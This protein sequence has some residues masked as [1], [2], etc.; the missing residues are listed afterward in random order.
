MTLVKYSLFL[1]A[2]LVNSCQVKD[3]PNESSNTVIENEF[4]TEKS[5][6]TTKK[7]YER[8]ISN[9]G[10]AILS[11]IKN[12]KRYVISVNISNGNINWEVPFPDGSFD[13]YIGDNNFGVFYMIGK[14]VVIN[15]KNGSKVLEYQ[16]NNTTN[17]LRPA[18]FDNNFYIVENNNTKLVAFNLNST[19]LWENEIKNIIDYTPAGAPYLIDGNFLL[20]KNLIYTKS[21]NNIKVFD[22]ETGKKISDF[23]FKSKINFLS[24]FG[25]S[26]LILHNGESIYKFE[27]TKSDTTKLFTFEKKFNGFKFFLAKKNDYIILYDYTNIYGIDLKTGK[28][29]WIYDQVLYQDPTF[30][31]NNIYH[32]LGG[33]R[34]GGSSDQNSTTIVNPENGNIINV[35]EKSNE[36]LPY[37]HFRGSLLNDKNYFIKVSN[38]K[39]SVFL[40]GF[41]PMLEKIVWKYHLPK[42][43]FK[44][45]L[46]MYPNGIN[47]FRTYFPF[48]KKVANGVVTLNENNILEFF[49]FQKKQKLF[50][51]NINSDYFPT[52]FYDVIE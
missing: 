3:I 25:N 12:L 16:M 34:G 21:N 45:T 30:E 14:F 33:F 39:D 46:F 48:V 42:E 32:N 8:D 20:N 23:N 24:Q 13:I 47:T 6:T 1:L 41:T 18:K 52:S 31:N 49:D 44:E 9:G 2:L 29:K 36:L 4:I 40:N 22:S 38:S 15:L 35:S 28:L 26:I 51:V 50:S 27:A 17:W 37:R 43:I 11:C 19:K 10:S 5:I 7:T